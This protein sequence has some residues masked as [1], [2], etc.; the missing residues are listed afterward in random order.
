MERF[1]PALEVVDAYEA[2]LLARQARGEAVAAPAAADAALDEAP[3]GPVRL[4]GVRWAANEAGAVRAEAGRSF[5][6]G[7]GWA[8]E[9]EWEAADSARGVHVAVGI[10]RA[11]GVQVCGFATHQD[12]LPP[13]LGRH[14]RAR[15]LVPSLPLVKGEFTLYVFLLDEEG[16]HVWDQAVVHGAFR[17]A[18]E[19]YRTG[20]V[21]IDHVWEP[22]GAPLV[23]VLASA[24]AEAAEA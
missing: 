16:L 15:L 18:G 11:D 3:R 4:A 24:P 23:P 1:G 6:P 5:L 14:G 12:G 19:S 9:V 22:A 13:F 10:D 8:L 2:F 20:L 7:E 21:S 17:V